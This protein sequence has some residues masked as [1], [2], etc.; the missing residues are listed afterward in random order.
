MTEERH[1]AFLFGLDIPHQ[2]WHSRH[3]GVGG[4]RKGMPVG[5]RPKDNALHSGPCWASTLSK[6]ISR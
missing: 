1:K 3:I 2:D 5:V 6:E 4:P